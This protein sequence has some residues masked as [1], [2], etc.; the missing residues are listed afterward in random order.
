MSTIQSP[1]HALIKQHIILKSCLAIAVSIIAN[2]I[3]TM[4]KAK[5]FDFRLVLW[6]TRELIRRI[7]AWRSR[8]PGGMSRS[9]AW[10]R[11]VIVGLEDMEQWE[12]DVREERRPS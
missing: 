12:R 6:T 1:D 7:D 3:Q 9:A 11:L 2:Y 10:R 5:E 4:P 8:I